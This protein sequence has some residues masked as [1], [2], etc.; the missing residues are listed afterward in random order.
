MAGTEPRTPIPT[1]I[2]GRLTARPH[3]GN[4]PGAAGPLGERPLKLGGQRDGLLYVPPSYQ[5]DRPAP[6]VVSLHGAGG[7]AGH[8]LSLLRPLADEAGLLLLAPDSRGRSWDV[9]VQ[10]GYGPDV[11]FLDRS[12]AEVFTQYSVDPGHLAIGGFSDGASYALCLGLSNGG[13]FTHI[14]AFS[15]GFASPPVQEGR[16]EI[17]ISHGRSDTVLPIDACSRRIVP[18]LKRQGYEVLYREFDDGH[19]VPPAIAG[20]ALSWFLHLG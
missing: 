14:L 4:P 11:D 13:L 19:V 1:T 10:N 16:P 3:P 18:R 20:E 12:L 6:L 5:A 15:P 9:I 2:E 17:Y 8:G 7:S